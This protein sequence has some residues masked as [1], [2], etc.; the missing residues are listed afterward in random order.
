M[1]ELERMHKIYIEQPHPI[2]C[3]WIVIIGLLFLCAKPSETETV[4][5]A[6]IERIA[7]QIEPLRK[8]DLHRGLV[9][10]LNGQLDIVEET[11]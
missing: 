8:A 5:N 4:C 2:E 9:H 3:L 7:L 11:V 10:C 1:T 6:K